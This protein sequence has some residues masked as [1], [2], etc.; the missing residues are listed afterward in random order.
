VIISGR[1]NPQLV[2]SAHSQRSKLGFK[3][4]KHSIGCGLSQLTNS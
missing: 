2:M 1:D 4:S 3:E